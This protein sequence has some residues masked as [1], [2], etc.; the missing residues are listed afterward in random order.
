MPVGVD[1]DETQVS[2]RLRT[3]LLT[4]QPEGNKKEDFRKT[5][6]GLGGETCQWKDSTHNER[7]GKEDYQHC[8]LFVLDNRTLSC[9]IER[10][11]EENRRSI[12]AENMAQPP[13]QTVSRMPSAARKSYIHNVYSRLID[14][15]HES[16]RSLKANEILACPAYAMWLT[17]LHSP[18]GT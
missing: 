3:R 9:A 15:W 1:A 10:H 7:G 13:W 18:E 17:M 8:T 14:V 6:R 16:I 5:L 4:G 12:P 2:R 11:K